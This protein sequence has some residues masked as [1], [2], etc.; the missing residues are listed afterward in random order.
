MS[1]PFYDERDGKGLYSGRHITEWVPEVVESLVAAAPPVRILSYGPVAHGYC[2]PDAEIQ[3]LVVLDELGPDPRP[4]VAARLGVLITDRVPVL[5]QVVDAAE[6]E[7]RSGRGGTL[8]HRAL[9]GGS[10]VYERTA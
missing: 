1:A 2:G 3:L 5:I 8:E 10:M 7:A 6:W 4:E 9:T